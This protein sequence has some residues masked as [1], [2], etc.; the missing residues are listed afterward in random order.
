M[1]ANKF[2][3]EARHYRSGD[4]PYL[5]P[6]DRND[7]ARILFLAEAMDRR[8][9]EPGQHGGLI[10]RTGLAVLRALLC[11]YANL[12]SGRCD[13]SADAIALASGV[14]RSTVF[15]ALDRLE[16]AGFVQR[17]QRLAS[18]RKAGIWHTEQATNAYAFN[19]PV[20]ARANEGDLAA[21]LFR[22][23]RPSTPE[24]KNLPGT[25]TFFNKSGSG[26]GNLSTDVIL[27]AE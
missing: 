4:E 9:R 7:R 10:K 21:P 26:I 8:T 6:L 19:F 27:R 20:D 17:F 3:R 15:V 1:A 5:R 14:S 2:R 11:R 16:A 25:S 24:F 18:F 22:R 12:Q 23:P 13:P